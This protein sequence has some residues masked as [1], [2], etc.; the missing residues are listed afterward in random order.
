MPGLS[1][2]LKSCSASIIKQLLERCHVIYLS[3][4]C[5]LFKVCK[6]AL[7][8]PSFWHSILLRTLHILCLND[9]RNKS[10]FCCFCGKNNWLAHPMSCPT[11]LCLEDGGQQ[12]LLRCPGN[13]QW[14]IGLQVSCYNPSS[15][16]KTTQKRSG[17]SQFALSILF[18]R[19]HTH[20]IIVY[21]IY[22]LYIHI[23]Y[24]YYIYIHIIYIHIIYTYIE[25][26]YIYN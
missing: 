25:L 23:I 18:W 12:T 8:I 11:A 17:L 4:S 6:P 26:L 13:D 2:V 15:N 16:Q 7:E 1:H 20:E 10:N 5:C 14:A 9:M 3:S 22:I 24:T 19:V 21:Y